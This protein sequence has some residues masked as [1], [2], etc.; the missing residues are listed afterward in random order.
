MGDV[1]GKRSTDHVREVAGRVNPCSR[2]HGKTKEIERIKK[3]RDMI[4]NTKNS[5][6]NIKLG[7]YV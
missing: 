5:L 2:M 4:G 6:D 7:G 1:A 3:I